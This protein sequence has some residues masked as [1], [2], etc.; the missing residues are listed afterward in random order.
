MQK[1]RSKST[2]CKYRNA[3]GNH[4]WETNG[5]HSSTNWILCIFCTFYVSFAIKFDN[6][7][8]SKSSICFGFTLCLAQGSFSMTVLC[9]CEKF[10]R[11]CTISSFSINNSVITSNSRW[12]K[13]CPRRCICHDT[14]SFFYR[15]VIAITVLVVQ[16][17][18]NLSYQKN[19]L[20]NEI[21]R[22]NFLVSRPSQKTLHLL[23]SLLWQVWQIRFESPAWLP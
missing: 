18:K 3:I 8:S 20:L 19:N 1:L 13:H 12:Q 5:L 9:P 10:E 6:D 7:S 21:L 16:M 4:W 22:N 2:Y 14:S 23:H 15:L 17:K 11:I